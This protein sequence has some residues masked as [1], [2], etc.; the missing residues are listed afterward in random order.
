MSNLM[1]GINSAYAITTQINNLKSLDSEAL[2]DPNVIQ[3]ALEQ[4]FSKMLDN[5][6]SATSGS[7]DDKDDDQSA[8]PFGFLMT[9]QQSYVEQLIKQN[10]SEDATDLAAFNEILGQNN[11]ADLASLYS[12]QDNVLALQ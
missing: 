12:L 11:T 3:Y 6:I 9:S 10:S 7:D 5:L 8:D 2:K 1:D 4:N